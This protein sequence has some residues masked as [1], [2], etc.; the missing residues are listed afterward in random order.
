MVVESLLIVRHAHAEEFHPEHPGQDEPRR[1]TAEGVQVARGMF[2][3]LHRLGI[4][5]DAIWTSPLERT[6]H[7]AEI[8]RELLG[9]RQPVESVGALTPHGTPEA[10]ARLLPACPHRFLMIV[11]HNPGVSEFVSLLTSDGKL[12]IGFER[13]AMAHVRVMMRKGQLRGELAWYLPPALLG[14]E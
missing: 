12:E 6:R 11:G 9:L 4:Q 14:L 8:G 3:H 5:P 10:V 13:A 2:G 7:T 1:L